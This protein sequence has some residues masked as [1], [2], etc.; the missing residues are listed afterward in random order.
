MEAVMDQCLKTRAWLTKRKNEMIASAEAVSQPP[1]EC[2]KLDILINLVSPEALI[3][4]DQEEGV[5]N[6][7]SITLLSCVLVGGS[8]IQREARAT[9]TYLNSMT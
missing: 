5:M 2:A 4:L 7:I 6:M 9:A 8:D 3:Y 1:P